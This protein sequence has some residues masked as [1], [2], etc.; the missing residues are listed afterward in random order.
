MIMN[1]V[2]QGGGAEE[3]EYKITNNTQ[4]KFPTSAMSGQN[5]CTQIS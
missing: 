5:R 2:I 4:I 1:P 3:K